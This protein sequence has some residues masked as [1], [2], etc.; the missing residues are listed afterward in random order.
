M[1]PIVIIMLAVDAALLLVA[2]WT[3]LKTKPAPGRPRPIWSSL[4]MSLV[5]TAMVSF[6]IADRH[7]GGDGGELLE[8]ASGLLMGM[9]LMS[10]LVLLRQR[11]GTDNLP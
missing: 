2:A 7:R 11:L 9:G 3:V 5:V 4:A 6:E 10:L 1:K 8:Y